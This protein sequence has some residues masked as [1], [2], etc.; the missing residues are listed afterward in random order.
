MLAEHGEDDGDQVSEYNNDE[1][2]ADCNVDRRH[3]R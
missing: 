2:S 1:N 3:I